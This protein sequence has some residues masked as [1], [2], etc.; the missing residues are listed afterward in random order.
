MQRWP[1][2]PLLFDPRADRIALAF[3]LV[4]L[5][6]VQYAER[7]TY[8]LS[9]IRLRVVDD[10]GTRVHAQFSRPIF[11]YRRSCTCNTHESASAWPLSFLF[12]LEKK[13]AAHWRRCF[14]SF[15]HSK[16][17]IYPEWSCHTRQKPPKRKGKRVFHRIC[18][19]A[20]LWRGH[21]PWED[22]DPTGNNSQ[23]YSR[24]S[25]SCRPETP[26]SSESPSST[27]YKISRKVTETYWCLN[28]S[29]HWL[30][31]TLTLF[32]PY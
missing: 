26:L 18:S 8:V 13:S 10:H 2:W 31:N 1:G 22:A 12:L 23:C 21:S 14:Y 16:S 24:V 5:G 29:L 9:A 32:C 3:T 11:G 28:F 7:Y 30:L 19:Q 25:L 20:L 27:A 17:F 4:V 15:Y 6:T